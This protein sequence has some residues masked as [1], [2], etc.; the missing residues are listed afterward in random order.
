MTVWG[1]SVKGRNAEMRPWAQIIR[2]GG[3]TKKTS[4]STQQ[5]THGGMFPQTDADLVTA[6]IRINTSNITGEKFK[7]ETFSS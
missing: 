3:K 6:R 5:L 1:E 7:R 2:E 4:K